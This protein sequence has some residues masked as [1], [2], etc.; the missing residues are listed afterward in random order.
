VAVEGDGGQG[1]VDDDGEV[2]RGEWLRHKV[3]GA[4][5]HSLY[6]EFDGSICSQYDDQRGRIGGCLGY[7]LICWF[8]RS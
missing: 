4:E 5:L 6:S 3:E 2:V 7:L 1:L 8:A